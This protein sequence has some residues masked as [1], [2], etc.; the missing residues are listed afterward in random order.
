MA[1]LTVDFPRRMAEEWLEARS[2]EGLVVA[3]ELGRLGPDH[4]S[5]R[6][7]LVPA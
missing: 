2:Y 6:W 5:H 3:Q 1:F 4:L 7:P